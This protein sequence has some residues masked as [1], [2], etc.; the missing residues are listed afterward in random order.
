MGPPAERSTLAG[1]VVG[2]VVAGELFRVISIPEPLHHEVELTDG[3]Q[4]KPVIV[5]KPV[6][7]PTVEKKKTTTTTVTTDK[8]KKKDDDEDDK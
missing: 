8:K 6:P 2:S 1:G 4:E 3:E 7:A 5:E